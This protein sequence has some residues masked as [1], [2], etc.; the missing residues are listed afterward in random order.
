MSA[1]FSDVVGSTEFLTQLGDVAADDLRRAHHLAQAAAVKENHGEV[2]K[3]LGDGLM[4]VFEG[5]ADAVDAAVAI[6]DSTTRI[7]AEYDVNLRVRVGIASGDASTE[8]GDW[9]GTP[10]V[11]ASRL[12]AAARGGQVLVADLS[13]RLAGSRIWRGW[14][15]CSTSSGSAGTAAACI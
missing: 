14:T 13:R 12:C 15:P 4:A 11:E 3:S 7:A 5:A 9:H 10:I 1:L 2:V 8:D 6:Q